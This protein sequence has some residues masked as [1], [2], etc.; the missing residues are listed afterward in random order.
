MEDRPSL[1]SVP[2]Y[3][4]AA[5]ARFDEDADHGLRDTAV[6]EAWR[7]RLVGWLPPAPAEVLDLGCGTGSLSLLLTELGH[8]VTGVDLADQMIV[9]ARAK[10][11]GRA[12]TFRVGDASE[13]AT[14]ASVD[15]VLARHLLWT[16]PD[17]LAALR[18]WITMLRP[19]GRLVLVEGRWTVPGD[20]GPY[21]LGADLMPW[22]GGVRAE[23]LVAELDPLVDHLEVHC[24]SGDP[25]L[26]GRAVDDERFAVVATMATSPLL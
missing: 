23:D 9:Q 12:A 4:N 10:C 25:L 20:P 22:H 21:A 15:A 16:L 18:R 2:D 14:E 8:R 17:P 3:W 7:S 13:P 6:R 1:L 5:S 11:A 19:G 24:L 26:W